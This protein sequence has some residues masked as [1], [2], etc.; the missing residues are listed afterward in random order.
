LAFSTLKVSA[1]D[2]VAGID[3]FPDNAAHIREKSRGQFGRQVGRT[4]LGGEDDMHEQTGEGMWHDLTPLL[5]ATTTGH[6]FPTAYAVGYCLAPFGLRT[7]CA[8]KLMIFIIP[9]GTHPD[10]Q[11]VCRVSGN[12]RRI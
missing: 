8:V 11:S 6:P 2:A 3:T 7:E 5:G 10:P 12:R 1:I 4:V 9:L